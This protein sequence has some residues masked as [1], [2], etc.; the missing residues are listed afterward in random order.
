MNRALQA[1]PDTTSPS[2]YTVGHSTHSI[3]EFID[4]LKAHAID[5]IVDVRRFP[6]SRRYP[7]F[8]GDALRRFLAKAGIGYRHAAELG[9]RRTAARD[10]RHTAWRSASFRA[11]AD[12]MET[13]EF[14]DEIV[15]LI[16]D[17]PTARQAIMCAEAVPWRCHR[18][19]ISDSLTAHGI[20]VLHILSPARADVHTLTPFARV[21]DNGMVEYREPDPQTALELER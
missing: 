10:S 4:L 16:D 17:I 12:H 20:E 11:Y 15:Q 5:A 1:S 21:L 9:G 3:D 2:I 19:L 14:Q 6:G 8:G 7:H 18:Q 13:P